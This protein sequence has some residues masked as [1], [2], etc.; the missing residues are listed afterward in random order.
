VSRQLWA[1]GTILALALG[2]TDGVSM[3]TPAFAAEPPAVSARPTRAPAQEMLFGDGGTGPYLLAWTAVTPG[4]DVVAID[5]R[6][7]LAG[8]D[9]ELDAAAGRIRFHAPLL[10]GQVVQIEYQYDTAAA[11]PNKTTLNFP[12]ALTV[13]Q[14]QRS[15]VQLMGALRPDPRGGS[16][17]LFGFSADT[18]AAGARISSLFFISPPA[19]GASSGGGRA[20]TARDGLDQTSALRLGAEGET[21]G[22]K[23][24]AAWSQAGAG[25]TGAPQLQTPAGLR[26]VELAASYQPAPGLTLTTQ[27]GRTQALTDALRGQERGLER[28]E[29]AYRPS[30]NGGLDLVQEEA[31]K[32][33]AD[34]SEEETRQSRLQLDQQLGASTRLAALL[35]RVS[36]RGTARDDRRDKATFSLQSRPW[37]RLTLTT[38]AERTESERDGAGSLYGFGAEVQAAS[39]LV[40]GANWTHTLT[41][42]SGARSDGQL[43]LALRGPFAV[44]LGLQRVEGDQ[45]GTT[46]GALWNLAAGTRAWL[47]LEGKN[48]ER[49]AQTGMTETESSCRMQVEPVP[50]V[51]LA[52]STGTR[53]ASDR[54]ATEE[55]EASLTL[56][57][58]KALSLG[59]SLRTS[60]QGDTSS[61]ITSLSGAVRATVIDVSGQFRQ[62]ERDGAGSLITRDYR[63]ALTPAS[64][65]KLDGRY[66][67]N[68]EDKDGVVQDQVATSLGLQT[69]VGPVTL[70]GS[71][72]NSEARQTLSEKQQTEV[73]LTFRLAPG[74]RLYSAYKA[75]DERALDLL[76]GRTYSFGFTHSVGSD[77]Y[78]ML[79]GEMTIYTRDGVRLADR[80]QA[81][82]NARLGLRF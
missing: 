64:W 53:T 56:A 10:R 65:L 74:S 25:F 4:T 16:P 76:R 73:R 75:S 79:E 22:L 30:K 20:H 51:R 48:T 50:G 2:G 67:E 3:G 49:I 1:V 13:V 29:L 54:L 19:Q 70:A 66:A 46:L 40:V 21:A 55:E 77:F 71:F 52:A 47:K 63:L 61:T 31:R 42:Q 39:S 81:R 35:E 41:E 43:R 11:K 69:S 24:R 58:V 72:S 7:A 62:R 26:Q 27:N 12:V 78:L 59:G 38:R 5:G 36:T 60:T 18:R 15:S 6:R 9:Y 44:G 8:L 82:A 17:A 80:D 23:Y 68:P 14:D 37:E 33:T 57:P 34:G 32:A 28:Y 45:D